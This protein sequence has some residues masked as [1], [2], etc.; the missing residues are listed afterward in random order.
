MGKCIVTKRVDADDDQGDTDMWDVTS[1]FKNPEGSEAERLAFYKAISGNVYTP[2][3]YD[4]VP[5]AKDVEFDL[6]DIDTVPL[7]AGFSVV[8]NIVNHSSEERNIHAVLT[9]ET[10]FYNGVKKATIKREPGNFRVMPGDNEQL[11]TRITPSDYIDMLDEH[12]LVKI[13]A[14]ANVMETKQTWSEEDDF[15][16]Y[17]P[18]INITFS[19]APTVGVPFEATFR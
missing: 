7:G 15:T 12:G 6:I 13:Y 5:T 1:L 2:P 19:E 9:A 16:L 3:I 8:V 10:V 4:I 11:V 17:K 14:I 18:Q